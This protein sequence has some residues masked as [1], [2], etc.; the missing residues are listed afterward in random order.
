MLW[1]G[2]LGTLC[3]LPIFLMTAE[4][5]PPDVRALVVGLSDAAANVLLG[6]P[7]K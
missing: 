2:G 6:S 4:M 7:A 1:F 5:L 3:T